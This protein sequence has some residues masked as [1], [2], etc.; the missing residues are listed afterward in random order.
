MELDAG[1]AWR[2]LRMTAGR[3]VVSDPIVTLASKVGRQPMSLSEEI[4]GVLVAR[5]AYEFRLARADDVDVG[6][7]F[8]PAISLDDG[9]LPRVASAAVLAACYAPEL[10]RAG[11][12]PPWRTRTLER[13][14][15]ELHEELRAWRRPHLAPPT[16]P[17]T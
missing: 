11:W 3:P 5:Y 4:T 8:L 9:L 7:V 15:D 16:S 6:M 13:A 1:A 2:P 12:A 14:I 10:E 17:G